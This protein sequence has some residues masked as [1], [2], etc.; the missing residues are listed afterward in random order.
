MVPQVLKALKALKHIENASGTCVAKRQQLH[1]QLNPEQAKPEDMLESLFDIMRE[2]GDKLD[3]ILTK[4][5]TEAYGALQDTVRSFLV[6]IEEEDSIARSDTIT[7]AITTI[8]YH[9]LR[10]PSACAKLRA[11]IDEASRTGFLDPITQ[12]HDAIRLSYLG[13]CCKEGMRP[14]LSVELILPRHVPG[15]GQLSLGSGFLKAQEL[16]PS[17]WKDGSGLMPRGWEGVRSR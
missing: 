1:G 8:L 15:D 5:K 11:E 2:K 4:V 17:C 9:L 13:A 14:H 10:S 16:I 6:L 12:Y 3:F 7:A